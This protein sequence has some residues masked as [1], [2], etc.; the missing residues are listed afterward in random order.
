MR[1]G[2]VHCKDPEKGSARFFTVVCAILLPP[3]RGSQTTY[4]E[5]VKRDPLTDPKHDKPT[6]TGMI[7]DMTPR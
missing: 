4:L 3:P 6:K 1:R 2:G 7:Q 5:D